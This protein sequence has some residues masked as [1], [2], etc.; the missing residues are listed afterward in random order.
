MICS[1]T[2][3]LAIRSRSGS[4]Q[5]CQLDASALACPQLLRAPLLA[6]ILLAFL[7][8]LGIFVHLSLQPTNRN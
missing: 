5:I 4:L 7:A 6:L 1:R 8:C 2:L 3:L